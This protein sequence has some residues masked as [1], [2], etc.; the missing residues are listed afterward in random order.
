M[1]V[2]VIGADYL[3]AIEKKLRELGI[4]EIAHITGRCPG[5]IK[6]ISIPK[7]AAFVLVFTDYVNHNIAKVVK[8]Q[9]KAQDVPLVYA[10]RSWCAVEQK[11][12][13]LSLRAS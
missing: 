5:E 12:A 10:K 6:K 2:V 8:N 11:L 13:G 9:A 7:T 1:T 4:T 3:G